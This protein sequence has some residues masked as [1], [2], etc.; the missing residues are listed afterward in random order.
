M[1]EPWQTGEGELEVLEIS[2]WGRDLSEASIPFVDIEL[3]DSQP[4]SWT[5]TISDPF[6]EY[7]PERVGGEWEGVMTDAKDH[8][9]VLRCRWSGELFEFVGVPTGIAH[10]RVTGDGQVSLDLTWSGTCLSWHLTEEAVTQ[11]TLR[12]TKTQTVTRDRVIRDALLPSG[13]AHSGIPTLPPL[14]LQHRQNFRP[15]DMIARYCER[16][17]LAWSFEG[18]IMVFSPATLGSPDWVYGPDT[19]V[20]AETSDMAS[21]DL[22]SSV[23]VRRLVESGDIVGQP[24]TMTT[25]GNQYQI[26]FSEPLNAVSWR[27]V[28]T[29]IL[30]IWS[31]F[32]ARDAEGNV[33][34][35]RDPRGP[36]QH[37]EF[38]YGRPLN[39][40]SSIQWTFGNQTADF[41]ITEGFG[42]LIFTGTPVE[43]DEDDEPIE[44]DTAFDMTVVHP[45]LLAIVG[46]R[47]RELDLDE[48]V[49]TQADAEQVAHHHLNRLLLNRA[50]RAITCPLNLGAKPRQTIRIDDPKLNRSQRGWMKIVRHRISPDPAQASTTIEA[51]GWRT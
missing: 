22:Y 34:A 8:L 30:G 28:G 49:S 51:T 14:R 18:E 26:T 47:K 5:L 21:A 29:P 4:H 23:V 46:P 13:T 7:H 42:Q 20:S 44:F 48:T 40:V 12:S 45:E 41:S 16:D 25:F 31:D 24:V 27:Q 15:I 32:T 33:V 37:A 10:N 39:N 50:P 3:R 35:A 11:E 36:L 2:A 9:F 17:G 43:S 19:C 1:A 38:L 6:A